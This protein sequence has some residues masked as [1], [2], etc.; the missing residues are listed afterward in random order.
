MNRI[1][2]LII[3]IIGI[4]ALSFHI[5][6]ENAPSGST[7]I[8][9]NPDGHYQLYRQATHKGV[10]IKP[11]TD[12]VAYM[13]ASDPDKDQ[14]YYYWEIYHES[15]EKKEGGDKENKPED[16]AGLIINGKGKKLTFKAPEK[17]GPY[18]LFV[19]VYDGHHNSATAN[20]PFYVKK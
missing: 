1:Y 2:V 15:I 16:L 13:D 18:R 7:V 9:K 10:Y 8:I 12:H 3:I 19:Y 14:L 20:A 11:S 5:T 4:S 6:I 17:E